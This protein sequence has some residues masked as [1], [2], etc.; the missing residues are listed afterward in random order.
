LK[1]PLKGEQKLESYWVGPKGTVES[2][3]QSTVDYSEKGGQTAHIWLEFGQQGG[4]LE[5]DTTNPEYTG[6]W[7]VR[8][9]INETEVEQDFY[10]KC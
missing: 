7:K 3:S 6:K 8:V 1:T 10:V 4:L 5:R 9:K 2:H